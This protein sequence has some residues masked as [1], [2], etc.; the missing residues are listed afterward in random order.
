MRLART[1]AMVL[2]VAQAIWETIWKG[3]EFDKVEFFE[4]GRR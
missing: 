1:F 4:K 3:D 2:P